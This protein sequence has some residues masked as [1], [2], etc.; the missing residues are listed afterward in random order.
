MVSRRDDAKVTRR[1]TPGLSKIII[2]CNENSPPKM[3]S[4][5]KFRKN[6]GP[7]NLGPTEEHHD[8]TQ[9]QK[10][11][12][13]TSSLTDSRDTCQKWGLGAAWSPIEFATPGMYSS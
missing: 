9:K 1:A 4:P 10:G 5:G 8:M 3:N 6:A 7:S 2:A 11:V 12:Q 13:Y